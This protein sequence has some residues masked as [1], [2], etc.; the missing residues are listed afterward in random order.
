M[1]E[2]ES[3][4]IEQTPEPN[5]GIQRSASRKL[6]LRGLFRLVAYVVLGYVAW[7]TVL[8]FYQDSIIFPAHM[9]PEVPNL[10][11]DPAITVTRLAIESGDEVES[12]FI[13]APGV[14][15]ENPSPIVVLFHGNA[16]TI[17]TQQSMIMAYHG[18]GCSVLLPEYRGYGRSAGKPSEKGIVTDAVSFY[19]EMVKR[20]D[21]DS[22][23]IVFHGKS[24][25]GGVAA[26]VASRRKPAAMILESTFSNVAVMAH[27]YGCPMFL[28][29]HPFYTDRVVDDID[30][31]L[32]IFHGAVDT[33]IPVWHGRKLR[34]LAPS[35]VYIEYNCGHN[36]FPGTGNGRAY[37]GEIVKFLR[38]SGIIK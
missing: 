16:E 5:G 6:L 34:D 18:L 13:P 26:Q 21:V 33:I 38:A 2:A 4:Q 25:G 31:P 15:S 29:K 24:L 32:L 10:A 3:T 17:H 12:W 28:A 9:A 19:D 30:I 23:R 35:A 14:S 11:V 20:A 22:T 1:A 27:G 8:Y 37:W 7:C 36:D